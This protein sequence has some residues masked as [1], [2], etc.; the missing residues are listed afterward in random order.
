M[1]I[2]I[3]VSY[4][5]KEKREVFSVPEKI[6]RVVRVDGVEYY[7]DTMKWRIYANLNNDPL[8]QVELFLLGLEESQRTNNSR[9]NTCNHIS[10]LKKI[11]LQFFR[12]KKKF[13]V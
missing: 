2:E 8:R 7:S 10:F 4:I 1:K 11:W 12:K 5:E 9:A 6:N 3:E 13:A